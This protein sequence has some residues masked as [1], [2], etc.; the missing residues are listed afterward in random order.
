VFVAGTD[1]YARVLG[2]DQM[3]INSSRLLAGADATGVPQSNRHHGARKP[4]GA[5]GYQVAFCSTW[6]LTAISEDG[7]DTQ[8]AETSGPR[9]QRAHP[10]NHLVTNDSGH[11]PFGGTCWTG[12]SA[13]SA[14]AA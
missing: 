11:P 13:A 3:A 6:L 2:D 10:G 14:D 8:M 7:S 1:L 4:E 9:S 5:M 12:A